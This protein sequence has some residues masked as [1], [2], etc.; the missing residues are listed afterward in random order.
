MTPSAHSDWSSWLPTVIRRD[1]ASLHI[2]V[3]HWKADCGYLCLCN[4][5]TRVRT[6]K[7]YAGIISIS[8]LPG[9]LHAATHLHHFWWPKSETGFCCK[10]RLIPKLLWKL[11]RTHTCVCDTQCYK[12][13]SVCN[14]WTHKTVPARRTCA[15]PRVNPPGP[16]ERRGGAFMVALPKGSRIKSRDRSKQVHSIGLPFEKTI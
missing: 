2:P 7:A 3:L 6:S 1:T 12:S 16:S 11:H 15:S 4:A 13:L 5:V 8:A 14:A 10:F 9:Q